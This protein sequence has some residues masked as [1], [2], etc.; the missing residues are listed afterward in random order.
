M[1][2]PKEVYALYRLGTRLNEGDERQRTIKRTKTEQSK[3]PFR[4]D[5]INA[6]LQQFK[7]PTRYLEIGVRN[8]LDNF[9]KINASQKH[10]VDP[11]VEFKPNPV[12]F[13]L[14][15]DEFFEQL[16]AGKLLSQDFKW[17]V[18]LIDGLHL[19]DQ[20]DR[21]I[22]NALRHIAD[23]GFVVLHDCNPPTEWH[24][25]ENYA[26]DLTPARVMWNGTTWKALF[27]QRFNPEVSVLCI[28]SD[29]GVGVIMKNRMLP[30]LT[31]NHNP[32]FEFRVFDATRSESI[33]LM[34]YEEFKRLLSLAQS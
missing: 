21:D 11:G 26:Y 28:D 4:F 12:D 7:R 13:K 1:R 29:W 25:R 8:P 2:T 15:S 27:R 16:G 22:S 5:V 18:I 30:A 14:A 10:S 34:R 24:A 17:D 9:A 31:V 3:R 6:L 23:D 32:Y 20:V 19:A 33:N